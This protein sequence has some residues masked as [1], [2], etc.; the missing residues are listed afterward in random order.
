MPDYCVLQ[1]SREIMAINLTHKDKWE[2]V[3]FPLMRA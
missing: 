1:K 3:Y 2:K